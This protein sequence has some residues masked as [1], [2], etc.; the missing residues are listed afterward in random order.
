MEKPRIGFIGLGNMGLGMASR[1]AESGYEIAVFNRTR[2]KSEEGG[3][4]GARVTDSPR[5]ADAGADVVMLGLP[6]QPVVE[7]MLHGQQGVFGSLRPGGYVV[8]MS[9]VPP[10]F[11][12]G[13]AEQAAAAGYRALDACV[14]GNPIHA[15]SGQ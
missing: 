9:T 12:R 11:A 7:A 13:L 2:S 14:L 10:D 8:D 1:L 4:L 15:R 3:R 6:D 5:E